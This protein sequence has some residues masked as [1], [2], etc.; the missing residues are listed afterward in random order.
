MTNYSSRT[1]AEQR[2]IQKPV[3][4]FLQKN[5]LSYMFDLLLNETPLH[6]KPFIA[7]RNASKIDVS[8]FFVA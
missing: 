7:V 5:P 2:R 1:A 8:T 3:K 6:E 4:T